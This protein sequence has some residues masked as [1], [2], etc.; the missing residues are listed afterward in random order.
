ME[1]RSLGRSDLQVSELCLGTMTFGWGADEPTSRAIM[2]RAFEAG[3]NFF[4]S[5]DIYSFWAE[6][7]DGGVAE[8]WIGRWLAD[9]PREQVIV[10]TKDNE[11]LEW[12]RAESREFQR[13]TAEQEAMSLEL[14]TQPQTVSG[15]VR[16]V[17]LHHQHRRSHQEIEGSRRGTWIGVVAPDAHLLRSSC[18]I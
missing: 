14:S 6:N 18:V 16:T 17:L 7:N 1:Y 10:A 12:V 2:D 13:P 8:T 5:A 11:L 4:D 15:R 3:I 9:K